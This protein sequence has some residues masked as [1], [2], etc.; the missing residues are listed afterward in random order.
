[1]QICLKCTMW[2]LSSFN[3]RRHSVHRLFF[4]FLLDILLLRAQI[5]RRLFCLYLLNVAVLWVLF[6][7][8][9]Y[10]FKRLWIWTMYFPETNGFFWISW[11]MWRSI[12]VLPKKATVIV[13]FILWIYTM[14]FLKQMVFWIYW[15]M[16]RSI[17]I[18]PKIATVIVSL[19]LCLN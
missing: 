4:W 13:S 7:F 6:I 9:S 8:T 17:E 14:Y 5:L 11:N 16:W 18:L 10:T 15:N 2:W 19:I 12:E 3:Q 1:M